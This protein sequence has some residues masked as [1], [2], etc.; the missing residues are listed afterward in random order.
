MNKLI[1]LLL[2][3][4]IVFFLSLYLTNYSNTYYEEKN[5][6]TEEAIRNY[7]KDLKDGKNIMSKNY[8]PS[9]KNYNNKAAK[10][11]MGMSNFIENIVNKGFKFLTKYLENTG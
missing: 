4:I 1:K 3:M 2:I 11:G 8:L 10:L 9:E 6:L 5:I 7:E